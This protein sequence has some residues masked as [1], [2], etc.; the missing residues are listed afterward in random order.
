MKVLLEHS[1]VDLKEL[2]HEKDG[3]GEDATLEMQHWMN[4]IKIK[5]TMR[6]CCQWLC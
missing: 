4:M 5:K 3:K 2:T 6:L 1:S